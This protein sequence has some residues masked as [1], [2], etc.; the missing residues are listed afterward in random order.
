MGEQPATAYTIGGLWERFARALEEASRGAQ[1]T[2]DSLFDWESDSAQPAY[3]ERSD[4]TVTKLDET[5]AASREVG[6][7]LR[8]L[9]DVMQA[10]QD[11]MQELFDEYQA[12]MAPST[13]RSRAEAHRRRRM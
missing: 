8:T 6:T 5:A 3:L 2:A 10:G 12:A 1:R 11:R 4:E 7:A 9:G 13:R